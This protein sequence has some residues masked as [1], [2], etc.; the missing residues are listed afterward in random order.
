VRWQLELKEVQASISRV[1]VQ[2]QTGG[3]EGCFAVLERKVD[4]GT[5][6]IVQ[7]A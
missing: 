1:A 6:A 5:W 7:A 3:W 4:W 2:A